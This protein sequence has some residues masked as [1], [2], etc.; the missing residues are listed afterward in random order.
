[1]GALHLERN[2][3]GDALLD[4]LSAALEANLPALYGRFSR[5][6]WVDRVMR[7]ARS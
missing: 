2:E 3:I 6:T 5:R 7:P 1:M 4:D